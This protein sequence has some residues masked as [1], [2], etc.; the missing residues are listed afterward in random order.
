MTGFTGIQSDG[1][2]ELLVGKPFLQG[3]H[4]VLRAQVAQEAQNEAKADPEFLLA[5]EKSS[6]DACQDRHEGNP[7]FR[8]GLWIEKYFHMHDALCVNPAQV[9]PGQEI[10]VLL[11][12]QNVGSG[13]V[14]VEEG[15]EARESIGAAQILDGGIGQSDAML[16]GQL[17][18]EFGLQ[19]A[20]DM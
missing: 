10:K 8:V 15:L 7:A 5:L 6:A 9:G 17:E 16:L 11:V 4:G 20:F 12:T 18:R 1:V 3:A 13:V 19:G 14:D 2:D